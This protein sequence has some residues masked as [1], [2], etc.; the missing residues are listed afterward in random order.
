MRDEDTESMFLDHVGSVLCLVP[1]G[2]AEPAMLELFGQLKYESLLAVTHSGW[3]EQLLER[4]WSGQPD[5]RIGVIELGSEMR[6]LAAT[7][8]SSNASTPTIL[9]GLPLDRLDELP[10]RLDSFEPE[11]TDSKT[12]QYVSRV[13]E[14]LAVVGFTRT[15]ECVSQLT[16]CAQA[17]KRPV[18]VSL[19]AAV[20]ESVAA[21]FA[22]LFDAVVEVASGD[23]EPVV[24]E[25]TA[26]PELSV[27]RALAL[28]QPVRRRALFYA[29]D[30]AG[31]SANLDALAEAVER[32]LGRRTSKRSDHRQISVSLYQLDVPKLVDAGV[33]TFDPER[34]VVSLRPAAVQL[35]PY[36]SIAAVT[37]RFA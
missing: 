33:A 32:R 36:L 23:H 13:D 20:S 17:G 16:R 2:E 10:A 4:W 11:M 25:H 15:Y 37:D 31:G 34:G 8:G 24:V 18:F 29:L 28:I 6:S 21:G 35:W 14:L 26:S 22:P 27:E 1:D 12:V 7:N 9:N 19:S 3:G 30:E 5:R